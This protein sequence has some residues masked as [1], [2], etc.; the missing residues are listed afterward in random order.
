MATGV[1]RR[2]VWDLPTRIFHWSVVLLI[3]FSWWSAETHRMEWHYRSGLAICALVVF[4]I[5]WG[6][7]GTDTSR[8]TQ[9]IKGPREV[10]SYI[11]PG[12]G[13]PRITPLGHNPLGGWSVIALLALMSAQVAFGMFAI[14]I[15]GLESGPL[16]F[17]VSFDQGRAAAELHEATFNILLA[18]IAVHIIAVLF[19]LAVK[20]RNLIG[21]MFTGSDIVPDVSMP[22]QAKRVPAWRLAA[23]LIVA[24]AATY[25]ASKGFWLG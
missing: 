4:R 22:D 24:I 2:F 21:R 20:R 18:L 25:G 14:D 16:S 9:F 13:A 6:L 1:E 5:L 8:F 17:L 19:Y 23:T 10:L 3:G 15:D 7:V 11:R 12:E